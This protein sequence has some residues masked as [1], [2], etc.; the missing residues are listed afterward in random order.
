[1]VCGCLVIFGLVMWVWG[2]EFPEVLKR[3]RILVKNFQR[4]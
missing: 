4:F 3:R 2:E 1:M